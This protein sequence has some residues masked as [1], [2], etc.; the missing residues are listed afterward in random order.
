MTKEAGRIEKNS[1]LYRLLIAGSILYVK[2]AEQ[3]IAK[4]KKENAEKIGFNNFVT[5][6]GNK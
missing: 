6:G 4:N 2:D 3:W 1:N 5:T